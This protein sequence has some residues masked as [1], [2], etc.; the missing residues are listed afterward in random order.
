LVEI[1][2]P[3]CR[4]QA[5]MDNSV[6]GAHLSCEL[7]LSGALDADSRGALICFSPGMVIESG[8][9]WKFRRDRAHCDPSYRRKLLNCE[10]ILK[11]VFAVPCGACIC[12]GELL[13]P[14]PG[15][16]W[17]PDGGGLPLPWAAG[18]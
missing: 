18:S 1:A 11:V 15:Q 9:S 3:G 7:A 5:A 13:E 12:L 6:R 17:P 4:R 10:L 16:R 14:P 8:R 2:P